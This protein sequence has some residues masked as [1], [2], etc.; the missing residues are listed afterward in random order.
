MYIDE[1]CSASEDT[2][3]S[4]CDELNPENSIKACIDLLED[5]SFIT[6][7][8]LSSDYND[9]RPSYMGTLYMIISKIIQALDVVYLNSNL[10]SLMDVITKGMNHSEVEIRKSALDSLVSLYFVFNENNNNK[11]ENGER[12]LNTISKYLTLS[13]KRILDIYIQKFQY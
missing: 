13:Q 6:K 11:T 3:E 2:I 5:E 1:V 10:N 9:Y 7:S 8:P 4:L 12:F